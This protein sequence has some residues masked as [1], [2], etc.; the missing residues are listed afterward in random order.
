VRPR[1][2]YPRRN[3]YASQHAFHCSSRGAR[4][5]L[6]TDHSAQL[7]LCQLPEK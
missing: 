2:G 3:G 7:L 1:D 6:G 4:G 5:Q